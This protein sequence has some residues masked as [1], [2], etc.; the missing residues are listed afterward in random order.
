MD[1]DMRWSLL[2]LRTLYLFIGILTLPI[3]I[4][5][6]SCPVNIGFE[7]ATM[8]NW[9]CYIGDIV[10]SDSIHGPNL[11]LSRTGGAIYDRHTIYKNTG[12][13]ERDYFGD[14]P[15]S[16]PNGSNYSVRLGN[17]AGGAQGE[18][19]VYTFTV[20][21]DRNDYT[22]TYFY[23]VVL[24]N[25]GHKPWLQ[26]KFTA[27]VFDVSKNEYIKC[28][29]FEYIS[30][31][32]LPGFQV[33]LKDSR[34]YY[35]SWTP[36]TVRLA[37]YA[38]KTIQLEFTTYDCGQTEHF[39]YAYIDVND[40]CTTSITGSALCIGESSAT[41]IAPYGFAAYRWYTGNFSKLLGQDVTLHLQPAPPPNTTFAVQ[42]IP[43]QNEGC[44][45][46]AYTTTHFIET[47]LDLK[48]PQTPIESCV[49]TGVDL[50]SP[51]ITRGSTNGLSF[52]Y[53][54]DSAQSM[55]PEFPYFIDKSGTYY[56]KATNSFGCALTK[57][58]HVIIDT[59]PVFTPRIVTVTRP[60]L[61][62]L[63]QS[64]SPVSGITYS[65]WLDMEATKPLLNPFSI[66]SKG[67]YYIKA[68]NRGGCTTIEPAQVVIKEPVLVPPNIF[69]PNGDGIHDQWQI[70]LL[71]ILYP[72]CEVEIFTRAGQ[73]IYYSTGY[74]KPWDGKYNGKDLP[75]AT[76]YFV[77]KLSPDLAP[78]SGSV[79]IIR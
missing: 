5:S 34:V 69:T 16:C 29:S 28:S 63:S 49:N 47:L 74:Q 68:T 25:P 73:R 64:V 8:E 61:A 57:E 30:S 37:G 46:T 26:P 60:S 72:T 41:L 36:V 71:A 17:S 67:I 31:G 18:K 66:N 35:K 13:T 19:L 15:V 56:I 23:A 40:S 44:V 58:V 9:K 45:D 76:Y 38:G 21:S 54:T 32:N 79:S 24:Q 27:N 78:V 65:Y 20:P 48:V 3:T 7:K 77:I 53:Y 75:I 12:N 2:F 10:S 11:Q 50:T 70:P 59:F 33:S 14:F 42:L 62:D 6:Q 39:G 52:S 55:Y 1:L 22:I 51:I 43:Y 4:L